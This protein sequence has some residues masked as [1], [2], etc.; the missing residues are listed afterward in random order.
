MRHLPHILATGHGDG[1]VLYARG[2][3]S[4]VAVLGLQL[5]LLQHVHASES[6][7]KTVRLPA[8]KLVTD[9]TENV[10]FGERQS[11]TVDL[12]AHETRIYLLDEKKN[13]T[14][15]IILTVPIEQSKPIS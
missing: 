15:K 10:E 5:D 7:E 14:E 6:G 13:E 4:H 9:I 8:P 12:K 1:G 3:R 11:W 2:Y